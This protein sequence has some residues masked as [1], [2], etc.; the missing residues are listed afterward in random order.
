[1][2]DASATGGGSP[3]G[4]QTFKISSLKSWAI[5]VSAAEFC[6]MVACTFSLTIS[7]TGVLVKLR[8]KRQQGLQFGI[9][10]GEWCL[11]WILY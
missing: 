6:N 8:L 10:G 4:T 5:T 3:V 2:A 11:L 9:L 1:M 7:A